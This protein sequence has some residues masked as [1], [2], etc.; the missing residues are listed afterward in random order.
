MWLVSKS[1]QNLASILA[2]LRQW[3][4]FTHK[5]LEM[6]G[7]IISPAATGALVLKHQ[8]NSNYSAY[9]I[10]I[11]SSQFHTK[12][13]H[14]PWKTL[15]YKIT[16]WKIMP[17]SLREKRYWNNCPRSF[18]LACV[19]SPDPM[20]QCRHISTIPPHRT[21]QHSLNPEPGRSIPGTSRYMCWMEFHTML[22]LCWIKLDRFWWRK[23]G[24]KL[25][26]DLAVNPLDMSA[27]Y[28][29][30]TF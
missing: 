14:L 17:I 6:Q 5:W 29:M 9:K 26:F 1:L 8:A 16:F 25:L 10:F 3:N 24:E 15:K 18:M 12:I 13:L 20:W 21:C 19:P 7:C 27:K 30:A 2:A 28:I 4:N 11:I 22:G 23:Q